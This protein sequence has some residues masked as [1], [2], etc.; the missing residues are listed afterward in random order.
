MV[1]LVII[2]YVQKYTV[3]RMFFWTWS[4]KT[5]F[6]ALFQVSLLLSPYR[7]YIRV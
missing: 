5:N 1:I 7:C 4:V 3:D 2:W 6:S